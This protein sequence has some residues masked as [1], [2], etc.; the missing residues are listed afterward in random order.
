MTSKSAQMNGHEPICPDHHSVADQTA[1]SVGSAITDVEPESPSSGSQS[2]PN[3]PDKEKDNK[4]GYGRPP[5][6]HRFKPGESGNPNGRPK[7]KRNVWREITDILS[8]EVNLTVR[9]QERQLS[10][11]AAVI[12]KQCE[13]ALDGNNRSAESVY[14]KA[15][16]LGVL[17]SVYP[18]NWEAFEKEDVQGPLK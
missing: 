11:V 4:V 7:A 10:L 17:P 15:K 6:A 8:E 1:A 12:L 5:E 16:D 9:G 14:K 13:K 3:E 18:V 2:P